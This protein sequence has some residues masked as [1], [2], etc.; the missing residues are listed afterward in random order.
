MEVK[1]NDYIGIFKGAASDDY[2]NRMIQEFDTIASRSSSTV[3]NGELQFG[4]ATGRKDRSIFFEVEAPDLAE[5]TNRILDE[6]LKHYMEE[7]VGLQQQSFSS[8]I[9]KV[10]RTPPKGGYHVWHSEQGASNMHD[11]T[12]ALVWTLYLNDVPEGQGETEF[13]HQGLRLQ[14]TKGTV[15]FFPAGWTHVHRG[16][17]TTTATK[18]IATGWYNLL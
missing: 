10:Q 17:F 15:C 11:S 4:D 6:C 12:R 18:Y 1:I 16:N 13:L 3:H 5:E 7:Y 9:V 2:C 8:A 14:P